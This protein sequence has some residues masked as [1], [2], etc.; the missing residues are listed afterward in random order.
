MKILWICNIP[1]PMISEQLGIPTSKSGGWLVGLSNAL[2]ASEDVSLTVC[3]PQSAP[4]AGETKGIRYRSFPTEGVVKYSKVTET[5]FRTI[6]NEESPDIIH[7]FGT[8]AA[9]SLA[10]VRAA[11]SLELLDR[12]VVSIQGLVSVIGKYHYTAGLPARVCRKNTLRDFIKRDNINAQKKEYLKRGENEI[13]L[14]KKVKHVIGRTDWDYAC[15]KA[16]NPA[17]TYH[18][19]HETMRDAFYKSSWDYNSCEKHSIFFSQCAYP[20]KGFHRMLDALAILAKRYPD[21]HLYTAGPDLSA[22]K[23]FLQKQKHTYYWK[24][25]ADK[26]H[27]LGLENRITFLGVLDEEQMRAAFLK[28]NVFASA[29]SIENS[30]NSVGEAMLLGVPTVASDVGGVKSML[31][32]G[33]DGY[34]FPFDAPYMLAHYI[35][36]I[37]DSPALAEQ[38]SANAQEHA[39]ITHSPEKNNEALLGIYRELSAR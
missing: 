19:C 39:R 11:E 23:S 22:N 27:A 32:H 38:L 29:S 2:C 33:K 17:R 16:I 36:E 7:V 24:Y 34:V 21:V 8:E 30:P 26:I 1:L 37:F 13:A 20:L 9:H 15:T 3:F 14:L 35:G 25:I 28:A 6:F 31:T 12:T 5:T 18:L 4:I 10:A